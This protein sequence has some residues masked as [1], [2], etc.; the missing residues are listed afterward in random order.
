MGVVVVDEVVVVV[1]VEGS[2]VGSITVGVGV[3]DNA[4]ALGTWIGAF[5]DPTGAAW[6]AV[7]FRLLASAR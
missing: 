7:V 4:S 6:I 1:V 5:V 3:D 2:T